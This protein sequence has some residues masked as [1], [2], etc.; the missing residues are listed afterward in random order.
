MR[1]ERQVAH[2]EG[3]EEVRC[4]LGKPGERDHLEELGL[5]VKLMRF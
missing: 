1:W 5:N 2:K 3:G 4:L